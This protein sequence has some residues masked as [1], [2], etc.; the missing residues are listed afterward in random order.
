MKVVVYYR[1]AKA[2]SSPS[3]PSLEAQR[4]A[5]RGKLGM[6][7]VVGLP[8]VVEAETGRRSARPELARALALCRAEGALLLVAAMD[9]LSR[10]SRFLGALAEG[11][12]LVGFCDFPVPDGAAGRFMLQMMA[13]VAEA[14]AGIASRRVKAAHR[15]RVAAKGQ[16]DR[17]ARHHLVPGAGQEAAARAV[18]ERAD[19]RAR[20]VLDIL[21]PM[22]EAGATLAA[23]AQA[24]QARG[25][26]TPRGGRWTPTAVRRLLARRPG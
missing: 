10:D 14:E 24:L 4:E 2:G 3:I 15:R 5:V 20:P 19:A 13:K 11:N 22:A 26:P 12:V 21:R 9:G 1:E 23:M 6:A 25:V 18:R 8:H 17:N 16:W 7:D